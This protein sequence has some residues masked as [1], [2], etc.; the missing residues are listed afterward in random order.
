[1]LSDWFRILRPAHWIKNL[2]V[3]APLL[4]AQQ[5]FDLQLAWSALA[6]AALFCAISSSVYALNDVLDAERDR[7]HPLKATRPVAAGRIRPAAAL[8]GAVVLGGGG[9]VGAFWLR[10]AFG[11]VCAGYLG[12]N[13]LY[14]TVIKRVAFL[15]VISIALGFVLRVVGGA[16]AIGVVFSAWLVACTFFLACLLGFGKRRHELETLAG[17]TSRTRPALAGYSRSSLRIA[18]WATAAVTLAAYLA[19]TVAPGTVAK[20]GGHQLLFSL[21]FPAFGMWRYLR[22]VAARRD[23]PPTES[24]VTDLPSMINLAVWVLVIVIALYDVI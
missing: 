10:P 19:Y 17:G 22:L 23:R 12:L 21:P 5:L 16:V 2:F 4:F 3:L 7:A 18:E 1:M 13:V 9:L 24:L 15:D 8:A 6:A 14:S 20:F 11:L